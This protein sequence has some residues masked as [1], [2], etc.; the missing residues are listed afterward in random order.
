MDLPER[1]H[2]G[3]SFLLQ[4]SPHIS[5]YPQDPYLQTA[6][7]VA[8]SNK[9]GH[10]FISLSDSILHTPTSKF[11]GDIDSPIEFSTL[12]ILVLLLIQTPLET[13]TINKYWR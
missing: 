9:Y 6:R 1:Q 12:N 5:S 10:L 4:G 8:I 2:A 3:L 7:L 13:L 11:H